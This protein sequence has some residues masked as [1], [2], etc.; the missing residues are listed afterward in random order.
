GSGRGC[1]L[2]IEQLQA[3]TSPT[4]AKKAGLAWGGRPGQVW[5]WDHHAHAMC[6]A[7]V[8]NDQWSWIRAGSHDPR[9][10]RAGSAAAVAGGGPD[11]PSGDAQDWVWLFDEPSRR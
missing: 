3:R 10:N 11:S 5:I 6:G 4:T 1:D 2:R 9:G 7:G 8:R